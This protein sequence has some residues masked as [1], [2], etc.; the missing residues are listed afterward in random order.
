MIYVP[1]YSMFQT[2]GSAL[3]S[4]GYDWWFTDLTTFP[5][6]S[7]KIIDNGGHSNQFFTIATPV[8]DEFEILVEG[9]TMCNGTNWFA[10]TY[11]I[12]NYS[13]VPIL[14][15]YRTKQLLCGQ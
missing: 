12:A 8:P 13:P 5:A 11:Q 4:S 10:K 1:V 14:G 9:V 15:H 3:V 6:T 7:T 2:E